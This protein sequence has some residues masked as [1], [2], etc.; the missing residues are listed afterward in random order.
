GRAE[1]VYE[2]VDLARY[3]AELASVF[4]SATERA[5][6]ALVI[7]CTPPAAPVFVD[8]QMWENVVLN[9]ISNAFKFTFEGE[10][11]V[12]LEEREGWVHL[13][14]ADT[15]T[16]IP[17]EALPHVFERFHRV[18]GT[19]GRTHEGTGIGL[20]LVSELV[21]LHGGRVSVESTLGRGSRFT[22]RIP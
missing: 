11:R 14:V 20:A 18:R 12:S 19:E 16:G 8:R 6:L 3:T 7:D 15:G 4:R 1:A 17:S 10:I 21:K 13:T 5:G 9:L 22:V 2:Q